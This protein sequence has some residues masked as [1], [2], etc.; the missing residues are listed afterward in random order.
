MALF[1]TVAM[2]VLIF[3]NGYSIKQQM[4]KLSVTGVKDSQSVVHGDPRFIHRS[5]RSVLNSS[6]IK[7]AIGNHNRLRRLERAA[8][9]EIMVRHRPNCIQRCYLRNAYN[10]QDAIRNR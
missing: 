10:L 2:L 1:L 9:M 8:N 5:G 3:Y 4:S 7:E 6:E